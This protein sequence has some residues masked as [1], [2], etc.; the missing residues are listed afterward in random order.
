MLRLDHIAVAGETRQAATDYIQD[1]LKVAPLAAGQHPH[2]STHNHLWGMGAACYLESIA[3]D[4]QAPS[5]A[6]P[7]WF[8]LDRFSGPP[9]IASWILATDDIQESLT[10]LGP[11][12]GTPVRLE[13]DIYTWDISVSDT[14][15]LPFGG[16]GPALIEWQ[17]P[18]RPCQNLP[19]SGCR[20]ISLQIQ[21]P[22]AHHMQALLSELICDERIR[23]ST[24]PAQISAEIQTDHGLVTLK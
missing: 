21:H 2:F 16:Y 20:L 15:D 22:Q 4:P 14:G 1:C 18:A 6:Y 7:R 23:F 17:P 9:R 24:G 19:D 5:L 11:E 12:F 8:G 10:R 13:R 3:V